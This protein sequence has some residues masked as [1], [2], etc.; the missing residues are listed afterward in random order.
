VYKNILIPTD[1][2]TLAEKAVE[3][4]V[5]LAKEI[6]AKVT[7]VVV[8]EPSHLIDGSPSQIQYADSLYQKHAAAE[9]AK[10]LRVVAAAA[11]RSGVTC[12]MLHAEHRT[13]IRP[14]SKPR[15]RKA[16]I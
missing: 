8:T 1:G 15:H 2:S 4:G 10:A 9:A 7:A 6:G 5:L 14:S 16:A 11:E 3:Q 12:E 13:C